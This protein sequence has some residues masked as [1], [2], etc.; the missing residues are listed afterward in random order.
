MIKIL[1][2]L[3]TILPLGNISTSVAEI[4]N[5]NLFMK[6][7]DIEEHHLEKEPYYLLDDQKE[8]LSEIIRKNSSTIYKS[9]VNKFISLEELKLDHMKDFWYDSDLELN[10]KNVVERNSIGKSDIEDVNFENLNFESFQLNLNLDKRQESK[11]IEREYNYH[12]KWTDT[13]IY[14]KL[15]LEFKK[16]YGVNSGLLVQ[17]TIIEE[18]LKDKVALKN[19][20]WGERLGRIERGGLLLTNLK[21]NFISRKNYFQDIEE[22]FYT[23]KTEKNSEYNYSRK[24][25]EELL[26]SDDNFFKFLNIKKCDTYR[27]EI[28]TIYFANLFQSNLINTVVELKNNSQIIQKNIK[29]VFKGTEI[30]TN[31]HELNLNFKSSLKNLDENHKK[32]KYFLSKKYSIN[33]TEIVFNLNDINNSKAVNDFKINKSTIFKYEYKKPG[34]KILTFNISIS[35]TSIKSESNIFM[36]SWDQTKFETTDKNYELDNYSVINESNIA[37]DD[38]EFKD[39]ITSFEKITL[40]KNETKELFIIN[41]E[42]FRKINYKYNENIKVKNEND[43]ILKISTIKAGTTLLEIDSIDA[44]NK[45]IIEIEIIN[46]DGYFELET[47]EI[48]IK[49]GEFDY[50]DLYSN[51]FEQLFIINKNVSLITV[52]EDNKLWIKSKELGLFEI[53]I[54]SNITKVSEKINIEIIENNSVIE[55]DKNI[56]VSEVNTLNNLNIINFDEINENELSIKNSSEDLLITREKNKITFIPKSKGIFEIE[57]KYKKQNFTF[58]IYSFN[59]FIKKEINTDNKKLSFNKN[60]YELKSYDNNINLID[61]NGDYNFAL[62]DSYNIGNIEIV[63]KNGEYFNIKMTAKKDSEP[64]KDIENTNNSKSK[65]NWTI[66]MAYCLIPITFGIS[67][68]IFLLLR[69]KLKKASL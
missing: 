34:G 46:E 41:G 18:V 57:F 17:G 22:N 21:T 25:L 33:E 43:N 10:F 56:A 7:I 27:A 9:K 64:N 12:D 29:V 55:L 40:K 65:N 20:V 49:K 54:I 37:E 51:S 66:I 24:K 16:I 8:K 52:F 13:F 26:N 1:K 44:K 61:L 58:K 59:E 23:L 69:K 42:K 48:T 50:I 60:D 38:F 30:N 5:I 53:E 45:K 47:N 67:L 32:I 3:F 14:T 35:H 2:L 19:K 68:F 6:N 11:V 39:I 15:N 36:Q 62:R 63:N 28:K 4:K 31:F